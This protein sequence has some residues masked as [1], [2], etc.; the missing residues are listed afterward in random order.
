MSK[1]FEKITEVIAWFQIALSPTLAGLIL[2]GLVYLAQP[3][4]LG[5]TLGISLAFIGV[6]IGVIWATKVWNKTG[7]STFMARI[8][9]TPELNK[10]EKSMDHNP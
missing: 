3:N 7:T 9:A 2:G 6:L 10:P 1:I 4:K 8:H 5:L